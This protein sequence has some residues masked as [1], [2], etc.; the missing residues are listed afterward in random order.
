MTRIGGDWMPAFAGMTNQHRARA[1]TFSSGTLSS[2]AQADDPI[3]P[4]FEN[5]AHRW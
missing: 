2:S 5:Y 1:V 4:V 3:I